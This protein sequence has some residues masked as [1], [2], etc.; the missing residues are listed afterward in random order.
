MSDVMESLV[1]DVNGIEF[2]INVVL[3]G[4]AEAMFREQ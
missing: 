2:H 1:R 3:F 4:G